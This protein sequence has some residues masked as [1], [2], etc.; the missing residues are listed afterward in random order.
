MKEAY[1]I[2]NKYS[3]YSYICINLN[4]GKA[5]TFFFRIQ[6]NQHFFCWDFVTT[7]FPSVKAKQI[8]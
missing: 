5:G 3:V 4:G 1:N 8:L 7:D 6:N 2:M